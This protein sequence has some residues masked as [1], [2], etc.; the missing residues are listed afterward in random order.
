MRRG[1]NTSQRVPADYQEQLA[2][3]RHTIIRAR[4][5]YNHALSHIAN[6]DQTMVKFDSPPN[7]TNNIKGMR[8]V[9]I[10]TT[11]AQKRGFT[12]ALCPCAD[13]R[14]LPAMIIFKE[15]NGQ[16]GKRVRASLQCPDN[17][18][19][20]ATT[21]GWMTEEKLLWWIQYIWNKA[22]NGECRLLVLDHYKPHHTADV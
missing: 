12:V 2:H 3:F 14:K 10:A 8:S 9:C 19:V 15:R 16:L 11:G 18:R 6:M 20:T 5:L 13:G 17:V 1:T 22:E 4:E 21:N 7:C